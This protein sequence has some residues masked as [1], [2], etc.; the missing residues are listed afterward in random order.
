MFCDNYC[1][2]ITKKGKVMLSPFFQT[3]D[4]QILE[5]LRCISNFFRLKSTISSTVCFN[6]LFSNSGPFLY[7]FQA[8]NFHYKHCLSDRHV[9]LCKN[10]FV[11]LCILYTF[12]S[13]S[14]VDIR[15]DFYTSTTVY[16]LLQKRQTL[17]PVCK[18][19]SYEYAPSLLRIKVKIRES[20]ASS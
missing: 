2:W 17:A 1:K 9:R 13:I 18:N 19:N 12:L 10:S 6:L 8:L 11:Y 7:S 5:K 4:W 20:F 15:P 14:D 3:Y 16:I